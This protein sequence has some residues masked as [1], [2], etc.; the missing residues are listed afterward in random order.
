MQPLSVVVLQSDFRIA[1]SLIASLCNSF[2]SVHLV[3]SLDELRSNIAKHRADVL[4]LDLEVA[5]VSEIGRLCHDFPRVCIVC[6]HRLAD[7][8]MWTEALSAGAVDICPSSDTRGILTAA[9]QNS[10]IRRSAAA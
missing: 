10:S 2:H 8:E 4:I 7:E 1:Q 6:T 3:R 5:S 9:M